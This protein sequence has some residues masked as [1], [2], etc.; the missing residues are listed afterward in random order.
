MQRLNLCVILWDDWN[1][2]EVVDS[3]EFA[4]ELVNKSVFSSMY[5]IKE[6]QF[7]ITT[8]PNKVYV[9]LDPHDQDFYGLFLTE[10]AAQDSI[11]S[12]NLISKKVREVFVRKR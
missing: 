7:N 4:E 11:S 5:Y 2:C 3:L 10:Q 9:V 6:F 1:F 8:S 12:D